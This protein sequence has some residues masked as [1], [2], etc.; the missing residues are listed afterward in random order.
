MNETQGSNTYTQNQD[1]Y[2]WARFR[3]TTNSQ[4]SST[5]HDST[6]PQPP[7]RKKRRMG[8]VAMLLCTAIVGGAL[9]GGGVYL[10]LHGQMESAVNE[11]VTQATNKLSLQPS[12]SNTTVSSVNTPDALAG[13]IETASQGVVSIQALVQSGGNYFGQGGQ[14]TS[15]GSGVIIRSD[16]VI[17]TNQHVI[18]GASR[19]VVYLKNGQEYEAELIGEDAQSDLAVLKIDATDLYAVPIGDSSSLQQGQ[20]AIVIGNPLGELNGSAT[21]GIISATDRTVQI[22]GNTMNVLQTD[23]AVNPG[24]SGG[25]LLNS[26]GQLIGIVNAKSVGTDV[27]G[28]G[29]AI[30]IHRAS[31]IIEQLLTYGYVRDRATLGISMQ[32]ISSSRWGYE[33]GVYIVQVNDGTAAADAG[34]QVGDRIVSIDGNTISTISDA[35]AFFSNCTVGQT[36]HMVVNRD[37]Q[38]MSFDITLRNATATQT[39]SQGN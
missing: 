23:A 28:L 10:A 29:F 31:S 36:I 30:P 7:R 24:N 11:A 14:S 26:Q 5:G 18:D 13:V 21:V 3:Q 1:P 19:I 2:G 27:E 4:S 39:S 17:V 33:A 8:T 35:E 22:N 25:A 16:G 12:T 38:E 34:L 20:T 37:G 15:S 6:P 9:G 32:Q